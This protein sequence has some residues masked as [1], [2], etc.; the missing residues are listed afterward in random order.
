VLDPRMA[1]EIAEMIP[2]L[3]RWVPDQS[4]AI[5]ESEFDWIERMMKAACEQLREA[6]L[7]VTSRLVEGD[8][9]HKLLEIAREK[10]ADCVF[11]GA[12]GLVGGSGLRHLERFMLGSTAG[13]VAGRASCSVEVVRSEIARIETA[14][15]AQ[16]SEHDIVKQAV[17]ASA[18]TV[19]S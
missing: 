15:L 2:S 4:G 6:G 13:V 3:Q 14:D 18:L 5:P 9:R 12:K 17:P 10:E 19:L 7:L 11:I 16:V 1:T 8:A